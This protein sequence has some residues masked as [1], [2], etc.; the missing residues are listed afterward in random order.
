MLEYGTCRYFIDR[1]VA[2]S[3]AMT[4][5]HMLYESLLC[6]YMDKATK[7]AQMHSSNQEGTVE[8]KFSVLC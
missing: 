1:Y 8:H 2:A 4:D 3:K 5:N 7:K 6:E